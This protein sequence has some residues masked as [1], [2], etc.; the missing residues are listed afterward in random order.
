MIKQQ[1]DRRKDGWTQMIGKINT[2][3]RDQESLKMLFFFQLEACGQNLTT[4]RD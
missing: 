3:P 4:I 2:E 1:T